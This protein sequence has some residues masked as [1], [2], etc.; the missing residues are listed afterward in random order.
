MKCA[1]VIVFY[2]GARR[3]ASNNIQIAELLPRIIENENIDV[4]V[5]TDTF[6]VVNKC[7]DDSDNLLDEF[8]GKLTTNGK[9]RVV[10]RDNVGLS[11]GGYIDT[12][13]TYKSEYDYW[14][15]LEDDV[16]VYKEG[17]IKDFIDEL[18]STKATFI[19]LAPISTLIKPHCGGGCGLTSTKYM[20]EIY[21]SEF[22]NSKLEHWSDYSGYDVCSGKLK[23]KNAE[24]EFS[25]YFKL[26]NHHKFSPFCVNH[27][28]HSSQNKHA[29]SN[30]QTLELIYTV[31]KL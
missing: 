9:I 15:F 23:E 10:K 11:F 12:F 8:D 26:S 22:V 27:N 1:K 28:R 19:A 31:G 30:N 25:S 18:E 13:N 16:I 21:T 24:I 7:G 3:A 20:E 6:F 14:M 4:G 2:F 17:Y 29:N 5:D